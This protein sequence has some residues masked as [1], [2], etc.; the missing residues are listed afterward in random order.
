MSRS[1]ARDP[2]QWP[3]RRLG[4]LLACT[5]LLGAGAAQAEEVMLY[6]A[7]SLGGALEAVAR[8]PAAARGVELRCSL[9]ASSTLALQIEEGAPAD[10]FFS[11]SVEWMDYLQERG[12]LAPGTRADLLGNSLVVVAP[13]G[14]GLRVSVEPGFDLA[15]AFAGHLALADPEHVPAG[16]YARQALQRLGW[17]AGLAGRVAPA[18][19]ARAA[20]TYVERGECAAGVVYATDA[21][22]SRRVDVLAALPDTLHAPIVYP[23]AMLRGRDTPAVRRALEVLWG[24]AAAAVFARHGFRVLRRRA[25]GSHG[26]E[27]TAE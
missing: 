21:A 12:L 2:V 6:A 14:E 7:A 17:W 5:S 8:G 4:L 3:A 15:G 24:E 22:A 19:D 23:L 18:P 11:A 13:R 9:A 16:R 20:L 25:V 1:R 26:T 10:L 27:R